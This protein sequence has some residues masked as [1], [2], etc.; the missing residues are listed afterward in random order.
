MSHFTV[1]VIGNDAKKQLEPF[2]E[3][4][5]VERYSCNVTQDEV[6]RFM[7]YYKKENEADKDLDFQAMYKKHGESWNDGRWEQTKDGVIEWSTYNP[8]SKWDWYQLGGRWAG[9]IM[10]K[11]GV[12]Y[13]PPNFSW[14]WDE[15]SKKEVLSGRRTDSAIKGNIENLSELTAFAVL[16][17]GEWHENGEMGWFGISHGETMTDDEWKSK[18][19][20]LLNGLPDDS[21]ISMYDC[22][23]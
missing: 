14:G 15:E 20:E 18:V 3:N 23:I 11:E 9:R 5:E 22:H 4:M 21:L 8:N 2:D 7:E 17:N 12:G 19:Q 6:D 1:M 10:V 16:M 13:D